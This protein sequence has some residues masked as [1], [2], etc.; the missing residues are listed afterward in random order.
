[1][2][3]YKQSQSAKFLFSAKVVWRGAR[4]CY[5]RFEVRG[6][7]LIER[8]EKKKLHT[9]Q[10]GVRRGLTEW[11]DALYRME[12][13]LA[14]EEY[15][16]RAWE[17]FQL[18][19]PHYLLHNYCVGRHQMDTVFLCSR[20][21]LIV[22]IKHMS[23]R[24]SIEEEKAQFL[25]TREDGSVESFRNPIDQVKRHVRFM[26]HLIEHRM[27]VLYAVIFSHNRTIIGQVPVGEPIFKLSG[28]ET[29]VRG[30]IADYPETLHSNELREFAQFLAEQHSPRHFDLQ[31]DFSRLRRGVICSE[32]GSTMVFYHGKFICR[33]CG[34][35]G[36]QDFYQ[37]LTDYRYCISEWITN[38]EMRTFFNIPS[39]NAA[40]RLLKNLAFEHDGLY[41]QRRYRICL[42]KLKSTVN[43]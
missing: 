24:I 8:D 9:L 13:G 16:D 5:A 10:A 11:K 25:R 30:M 33:N 15:V 20:F 38:R 39:I 43:G 18:K 21:I 31:I 26:E 14:G 2:H 1:M 23:G 42:Q 40:G 37:G 19:E 17:D 34:R 41:K 35:T 36:H 29:F 12:S 3:S 6:M 7:M 28:L 32:C 22:E 4:L 27:P